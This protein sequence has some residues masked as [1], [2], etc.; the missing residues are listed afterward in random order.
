MNYQAAGNSSALFLTAAAQNLLCLKLAQELGV[1]IANPWV[2]WFK[3]A[4]VPAFTALLTT[5]LILYKLFPPEVKD[6]PEAPAAAAKKLEALGPVTQNEWSMVGTML[7]AVTLWVFGYASTINLVSFFPILLYYLQS[8]SFSVSESHV[9]TFYL[10]GN[11][12]YCECG[13]RNAGTLHPSLRG[14]FELER[15][16]PGEICM[17][18]IDVVCDSRR[19]G[20]KLV[21]PWSC[22]VDV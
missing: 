1:I 22:Q 16:P 21:Q 19:H 18:H 13:C 6:T 17:G 3:A 2:S 8:T 4:F 9:I 11:P 5:P 15:L 10:Q 7:L 14:S 20:R 12:R